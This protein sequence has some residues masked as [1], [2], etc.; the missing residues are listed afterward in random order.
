MNKHTNNKEDFKMSAYDIEINGGKADHYDLE[1][2]A[3]VGQV[4]QVGDSALEHARKK[5]RAAGERGNKSRLKDIR[6]ARA[7]LDRAIQQIISSEV[8][9]IE[10]ENA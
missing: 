8:D 3:R 10:R 2:A 7:S 1:D 9:E 5:L 4:Y 6:E